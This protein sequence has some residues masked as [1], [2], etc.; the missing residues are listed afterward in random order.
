MKKVGPRSYT[1][2]NDSG[3][4]DKKASHISTDINERSKSIVGA[5]GFGVAEYWFH[6]GTDDD[7]ENTTRSDFQVSNRGMFTGR[8]RALERIVDAREKNKKTEQLR[9]ITEKK[10]EQLRI[11][12]E[13]RAKYGSSTVV[14]NTLP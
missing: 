7:I 14:K 2:E 6:G 4:D 5:G 10:T 9:I 8:N 1:W 3:F 13:A 11:I 12:A